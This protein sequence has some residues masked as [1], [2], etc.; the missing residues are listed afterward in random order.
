[1]THD[2]MS[3]DLMGM[4]STRKNS[5]K[6]FIDKNIQQWEL[7]MNRWHNFLN[8]KSFLPQKRRRSPSKY[9]LS[10]FIEFVLLPLRVDFLFEE[11]KWVPKWEPCSIEQQHN[12]RILLR[13]KTR[14]EVKSLSLWLWNVLTSLALSST[15]GPLSFLPTSSDYFWQ[16]LGV[17]FQPL[18]PVLES[19]SIV[20]T[21]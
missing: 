2:S 13:V 14:R 15:S 21:E 6:N 12:D 11:E 10:I 1:M 7:Q 19:R 4:S 3:L 9:P 5:R 18:W 17:R 8:K 16:T 20:V